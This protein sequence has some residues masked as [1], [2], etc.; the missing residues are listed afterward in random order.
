MQRAANV[1]EYLEIKNEWKNELNLLRSIIQKTELV[2]CIKWGAPTYTIADKNVVGLGAFKGYVGLWF[3]QGALLSDTKKLLLNAQEGKTNA[4][5]QMRFTSLNEIDEDT[6][7]Y[8]LEEAILNQKEGKTVPIAKKSSKFKIPTEL[9][10]ALDADLKAADMFAKFTAYKQKEYALHIAQ[11]KREAT[12]L[13]RIEKII[14][15]I[16]KGIGLND[17]YRN[18]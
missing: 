13:K 16:L 1:E 15:M 9:K 2:E 5:R 6:I 8:Y 10:Q 18:C 11:A 14:P 3:F 12:K 17:K 4:M 7:L